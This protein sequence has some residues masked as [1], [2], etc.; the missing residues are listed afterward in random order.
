MAALMCAHELA[1]PF[2]QDPDV[3]HEQSACRTQRTSLLQFW[4]PGVLL[5]R[6]FRWVSEL[7]ESTGIASVV[8]C[9]HVSNSYH[10]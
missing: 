8:T 2:E 5:L 10:R 7:A 1:S 6:S 3:Y 9:V 4:A